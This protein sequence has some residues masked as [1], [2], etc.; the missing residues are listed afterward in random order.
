MASKKNQK[1]QSQKIRFLNVKL[2]KET[3]PLNQFKD[4]IIDAANI[5]I[6]VLDAEANILVWNRVAETICGYTKEEAIGNKKIWQQLYP[7]KK[8]REKIFAKISKIV[9]E[10][11]T[12]ENFET[13]IR[14]KNGTRKTISWNFRDLDGNTIGSMAIGR[15]IT[16]LKEKEHFIN[17]HK[18]LAS[19]LSDTSDFEKALKICMDAVLKESDMDCGGFYLLDKNTGDFNLKYSRGLSRGFIDL[20]KLIKRNSGQASLIMRGD[21]VHKF[22]PELGFNMD[23]IRKKE[24]LKAIS[25]LPIKYNGKVIA[26]MNIASHK[27][28]YLDNHNRSILEMIA[29]EAGATIVRSRDRKII[30]ASEEKYRTLVEALPT[31][32]WSKDK[33]SVFTSCNK[34][35]A[36]DLEINK[37]DIAGKTDYDFFSKEDADNYVKGDRKV[38]QSGMTLDTEE[39]LTRHG[40]ILFLHTIKAPLRDEKGNIS[41]TLIN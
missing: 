39:S 13:I 21:S 14:C 18:N 24:G 35:L 30:E 20:I 29:N 16:E 40:Q 23:P 15:D 6:Y 36:D 33:N 17:I 31:R 32:I 3:D 10:G 28:D 25:I 19:A 26:C 5:W 27:V 38:L 22:Y 4:S 8:Y 37:E 41:G 34:A 1:R 9:K 11:K 2:E 12:E 7:D